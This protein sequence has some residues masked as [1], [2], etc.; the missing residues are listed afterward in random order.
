MR[1]EEIRF[2]RA[3][4][5]IAESRALPPEVVR[6]ALREALI[7]AYRK[8]TNAS[9]AQVIEAEIDNR[10]GRPRIFVEKEV[11]DE[12]LSPLTE[13]SLEEARFFNPEAQYGDIV[14]VRVEI[15]RQFGRIAAQSAKQTILQKIRN[16]ERETVYQ[17]FD[18]KVGEL[19]TATV[20]SISSSKVTLTLNNNRVEAIL[21]KQDQIPGE[22]LIPGQKVRVYISEVKR[23]TKS[24]EIVVSRAHRNM[25][26]RLLETEVPEIYG[27]QVEIKNIARE[28][29]GRSKIAVIAL[30]DN[31]DP[32]GACVGQRGTR[33]Q[34]IVKE[35]HNE[36]IDVIEWSNNHEEFIKKALNPAQA[37]AVYLDD[38]PDNGRTAVVLVPDENLSQAIGREGQNARLAAKLTHWRID[39]KAVS[40]AVASALEK[41]NS[42]ELEAVFAR[43]PQL[44]SEAKR[45]MDKKAANLTVQPEEYTT[46][47]R[48]AE[49]VES[50]LL[51]QRIQAR[52]ARMAEIDAL[53]ATL[54]AHAF[55]IPVN[56]LKLPDNLIE[57]LQPLENV[58]E[59]LLRFLI[60]EKRIHRLL[61]G[62]PEGSVEALQIALDDAVLEDPEVGATPTPAPVAVSPSKSAVREVPVPDDFVVNA[63]ARTAA[64]DVE[65]PNET[66]EER[67]RRKERTDIPDVEVEDDDLDVLGRS[68][69]DKKDNKK[70]KKGRT[71]LYDED[72]GEMVVRRQHKR[73]GD[74]SDEFE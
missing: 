50:H 65:F 23:G 32:V 34:G 12:V 22:R 70:K 73:T 21:R 28:A 30:M 37:R 11:V 14:M 54:P 27:G 24:P 62:Q 49:M 41:T 71:I 7:S 61:H 17:E 33:I 19:V 64:P 63:P 1:D 13:V 18:A 4:Q 55:Q 38:D 43:N 68:K 69:G 56:R 20:Q 16:A 46:L 51:Q 36:K 31:I 58:G 5:E 72:R 3:F 8:E 29:G 15:T 6:E 59:I 52:Q 66:Q 53:R 40:E 60:D 57:A 44:V 74:W 48:F 10:L 2:D 42:P 25:L 26:K 9:K 45:I 47:G 67:R 35:L 39:I